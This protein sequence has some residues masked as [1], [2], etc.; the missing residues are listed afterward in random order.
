MRGVVIVRPERDQ[1]KQAEQG[2]CGTLDGQFRPLPLCLDAEMT[3]DLGEGDLDRPAPDEP[4]E[5]VERIGREIGAQEGLRFEFA[6]R[7]AHQDV[8]DGNTTARMV[9]QSSAGNNLHHPFAVAVPSRHQQ[10]APTC[11]R[12]GEALLQ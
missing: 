2:R 8:A 5:N 4:A 10:R 7:I 12:V 6:E 9:S 1:G 3:T 11:L